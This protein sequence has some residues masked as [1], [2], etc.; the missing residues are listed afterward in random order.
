MAEAVTR[1]R[2][3]F[4]SDIHLGTKAC[5][6]EMVLD[7]LR[8]TESDHLYLVGDIIDGWRLRKRWYWPQAHNDVIQKLLRRARKGTEV[9]YIPGNHD[10][11]ARNFLHMTFGDVKIV[12]HAI[13]EGANGKKYLVI[14]GDQFDVVVRHAAWLAHI[15]DWAYVTLLTI[16]TWL[17]RARRKLGLQY[18]SLSAY[19]KSKTKK[20]VEFVGNY[21]DALVA[22]ARRRGVDGVVCG[23]IHTA[24]SKMM[25]DIHYLNDGDWVE[26]CTA[27]VEHLDGTFEVIEWAKLSTGKQA[28]ITVDAPVGVAPQQAAE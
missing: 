13:H 11:F 2:S 7:F 10:E 23:H 27:L 15:G 20:A 19:L 3:I 1:Y 26:S 16:N 17:N 28:E 24:E 8:R 21:E 25:G 18:W 12:N 4:I 14:H 5:Q 9:T 6:A 22:E